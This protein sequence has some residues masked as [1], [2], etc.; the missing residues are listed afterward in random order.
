MTDNSSFNRYLNGEY[1]NIFD[2][3]D[4][5]FGVRYLMVVGWKTNSNGTIVWKCIN[6]YGL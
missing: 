6:T 4:I 2:E 5:D 1:L 3:N